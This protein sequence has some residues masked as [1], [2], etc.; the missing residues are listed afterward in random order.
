[1]VAGN[2]SQY[3][4]ADSGAGTA[5]ALGIA[6]LSEL[7]VGVPWNGREGIMQPHQHPGARL[8]RRGRPKKQRPRRGDSLTP[9]MSHRDI[10]AVLGVTR[11]QVTLWLDVASIPQDEFERLIEADEPS[12]PN[13]LGLLARSRARKSVEYERKCP[14][15]GGLLRIEKK[16]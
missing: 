8:V 10:A 12:T 11:R 6:R 15:C 3:P 14:H 1:M 16:T 13:E 7:T 2:E 4:F 9:G 5:A